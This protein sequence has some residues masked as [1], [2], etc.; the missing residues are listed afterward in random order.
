MAAKRRDFR[1]FGRAKHP[2]R[3]LIRNILF[4]LLAFFS[5]YIIVTGLFLTSFS[6]GSMAMEPTFSVGDRI[7]STP[8]IFGPKLPFTEKRLK[9]VRRPVRGELVICTPTF[10]RESTLWRILSP[11]TGF[12]T[13]NLFDPNRN[14]PWESANMVKRVVGLPG[15]T[16]KIEDFIAYIQLA[17][18]DSFTSEI[19]LGTAKYAITY[20]P[21][22]EG[23]EKGLP[24][25]GYHEEM[26]LGPDEYYVLGDNR[27]GSHDSRHWGPLHVS[28]ITGK[29]L[30][31][32]WPL[33]KLGAP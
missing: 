31:R 4:F 29:V 2:S 21:T 23:W 26:T 20:S 24:F 9:E 12:F 14:V 5:L 15:D 3:R 17:D 33:R 32:Y 7:L 13:L 8:L 16:I 30:F 1:H 11:I 25:S 28:S 18:E 10:S 22:P 19:E 6:I 27:S